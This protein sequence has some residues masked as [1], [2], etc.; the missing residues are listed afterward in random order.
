MLTSLPG[1]VTILLISLPS[2]HFLA[3]GASLA[4]FSNSSFP[5][6]AG[7]VTVTLSGPLP[8]GTIEAWPLGSY[9][10]KQALDAAYAK[11][12]VTANPTPAVPPSP[13][14][15][16]FEELKRRLDK[17]QTYEPPVAS[18]TVDLAK[19]VAE[20]EAQLK[21]A[22]TPAPQ[23]PVATRQVWAITHY[24]Q[25]CDRYGRCTLNPVYG[26]KEQP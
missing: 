24:E 21:A 19:R 8:A 1:M 13:C 22:Q 9:A 4:I 10:D 16:K 6:P 26:W 15:Q 2:S 18:P 17:M 14:D 11:F 7:T 25:I 5:V 23:P 3:S 12:A 20:L